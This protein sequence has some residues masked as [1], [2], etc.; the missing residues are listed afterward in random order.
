M[1]KIKHKKHRNTGLIFEMLVKK[2]TSNVL[3]GEGINEISS[4]IKKHFSNNSQ[5]RQELTFYQMLTKEKVKSPNLANELIESIKEARNSLDIEKLNKEKYRLYKDITSYFGG[6]SFFDIKVENYQNYASIY[7]LFEYNQS[8]N[9]PVMVSNKQNLIY[10]TTASNL[11]TLQPTLNMLKEGGYDIA[12]VMV[13]AHPIVSFLRNFKR[14]RKVPAVG[15]LGTWGNVYNLLNDYKQIFGDNFILVSTP[16]STPE[17]K[18]EIAKF[19]LAIKQGK[20]RDYFDNL[21]SSGEFTSTFRKDDS[22]LFYFLG[23]FYFNI[24]I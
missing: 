19:N 21:L 7:T 17:E 24:F 20:L 2:M 15:V 13:Y 8:D 23:K 4:I 1:K 6:D 22:N 18:T 9:P 16:A 14:E 3:Q 5:I 11:S 10:D 12:M